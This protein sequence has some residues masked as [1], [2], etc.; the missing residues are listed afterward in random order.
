[1]KLYNHHHNPVL[2]YFSYPNK[3]PVAYLQL[4]LVPTRRP[5]Y[6]QI[7]LLDIQICFYFSLLAS[8]L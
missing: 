3:I 8:S 7:N 4:I 5:K 6:L 2:D 1:M